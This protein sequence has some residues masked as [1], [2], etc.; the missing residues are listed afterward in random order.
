MTVSLEIICFIFGINCDN[1]GL[2]RTMSSVMPWT[3]VACHGIA[4]PGFTN[5][6]RT[7]RPFESTMAISTIA[8]PADGLR[9]VV[10]VSRNNG[11][12]AIAYLLNYPT[13]ATPNRR[14][15]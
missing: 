4:L 9:P 10:S 3:F 6:S 8:S 2:P 12:R 14:C 11:I 13:Y 7:A 15:F 1:E 5:V